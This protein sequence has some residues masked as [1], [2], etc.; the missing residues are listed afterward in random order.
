[1]GSVVEVRWLMG[2][3]RSPGYLRVRDHVKGKD[4]EIVGFDEK[5][6]VLRIERENIKFHRTKGTIEDRFKLGPKKS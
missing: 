1:M 6:F 2:G 4:W 3:A 5:S